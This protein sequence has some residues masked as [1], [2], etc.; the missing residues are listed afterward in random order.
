M[1][2]Q[3]EKKPTLTIIKATTS[4]S[5]RNRNSKDKRLR[6]AAYCRVSTDTDEQCGSFENQVTYYTK[7][8]QEN[9][10][11]IYAGVY[12]DE[13]YSGAHTDNRPQF[14]Q[15]IKDAL[16]GKIDLILMKSISRLGR[17]TLENIKYI[18][19]L[20]ERGIGIRFEEEHV[21]TLA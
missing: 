14:M 21:D 11:W 17:N 4:L 13:G 18:R 3:E 19:L 9:P 16:D 8:I 2:N 20:K 1:E 15:M 6:V 7:L 10:E 12:A 5:Q